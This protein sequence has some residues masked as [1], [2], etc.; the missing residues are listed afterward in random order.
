MKELGKWL[1]L[2]QRSGE[3]IMSIQDIAT[4]ESQLVNEATGPNSGH[5]NHNQMVSHEWTVFLGMRICPICPPE[6]PANR[7]SVLSFPARLTTV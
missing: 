3:L 2:V 6:I 1:G 5:P 7:R 4:C